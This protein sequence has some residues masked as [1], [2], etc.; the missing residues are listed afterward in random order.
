VNTQIK[1]TKSYPVFARSRVAFLKSGP[2]ILFSFLFVVLSV[3]AADYDSACYIQFEQPKY[4]VCRSDTNAVITVT[5]SGDFRQQTMVEYEV[6]D[7]TATA[8]EDYKPVGGQL[9]FA[10]FENK[11]T[12]FIPILSNPDT[13]TDR[14][15]QLSLVNPGYH[16]MVLESEATLVITGA[17]SSAE[18]PPA[19]EISLASPGLVAISWSG[20]RLDCVLE[21]STDPSG[22]WT[23]VSVPPYQME[24]RLIVEETASNILYFYR[25]RLK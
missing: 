23:Q 5:R 20:N 14:T 11:K 16:A 22:S 7:G 10:P 19:V 9:V 3:S 21:K 25:L 17:A 24:G 6:A 1:N 18:P 15:V 2:A 4:S 13:N 8:G 12:F